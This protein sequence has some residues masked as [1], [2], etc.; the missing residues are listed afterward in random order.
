M[1]NSV[2]RK[3]FKQFVIIKNNNLTIDNDTAACSQVQYKNSNSFSLFIY[4][5]V[6]T[7]F[8]MTLSYNFIESEIVSENILCS[9]R[10]LKVLI[11]VPHILYLD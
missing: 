9:N 7:V 8:L 11:E 2:T 3:M 6:T 5:V 1:V 10:K 4:S